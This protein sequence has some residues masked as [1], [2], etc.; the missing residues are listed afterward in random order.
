LFSTF[1]TA[2]A[3]TADQALCR[4]CVGVSIGRQKGKFEDNWFLTI[5]NPFHNGHGQEDNTSLRKPKR[6]RS[7][8]EVEL[9]KDVL[10]SYG[11]EGVAVSLYYHR[12]GEVIDRRI[13]HR[14]KTISRQAVI[15]TGSPAQTL[16]DDLR[17]GPAFFVR[18]SFM[19]SSLALN[20]CRSDDTID[21]LAISSDGK[22][23]PGSLVSMFLSSRRFYVGSGSQ[24][25]VIFLF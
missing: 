8:F 15:T 6:L 12:T 10:S 22:S 2:R 1:R 23:G 14:L 11:G 17:S 7:N 9:A 3:Q 21:F 18:I 20:V 5:L 24:F 25:F 4:F 13:L 16:I 19:L